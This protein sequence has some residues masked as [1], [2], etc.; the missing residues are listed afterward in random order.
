MAAAS[1]TECIAFDE[2]FLIKLKSARS[3]VLGCS[4]KAFKKHVTLCTPDNPFKPAGTSLGSQS[5][6]T[7]L[8]PGKISGTQHKQAT[9][10]AHASL[11]GP[12]HSSQGT[13][14]LCRRLI[15]AEDVGKP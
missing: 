5:L 10:Q 2:Q 14:W 6:S 8:V 1:S 13:S 4:S 11:V 12:L 3:L 9:L 7:K 15:C